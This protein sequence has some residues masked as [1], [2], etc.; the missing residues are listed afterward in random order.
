M[1]DELPDRLP[2]LPLA[3][4]QLRSEPELR[5]AVARWLTGQGVRLTGRM[6]SVA[7]EPDLITATHDTIYELKLVLNRPAIYSGLGQL[8][9]YRQAINPQAR[10]VLVGYA[11][12]DTLALQP[13]L[14]GLG[15]EVLPWQD[16]G[17]REGETHP[18]PVPV[19]PEEPAA[20]AL[21]V[22]PPPI[23]HLHILHWNVAALA[24]ARGIA[25][26]S[27]LATHMGI[28]RQGLYAIWRGEAAQVSLDILARLAHALDADPGAWFVGREARDDGGTGDAA[29]RASPLLWN[30]AAQAEG[31]GLKITALGFATGLHSR[32]LSTIWHGEAQAVGLESL[33]K[34]ALALDRP[35]RPFHIGDLFVWRAPPGA[36]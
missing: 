13:L 20:P 21:V 26:A 15:V 30:I 32:S 16:A 36:G 19:P 29:R 28:S 7:G 31:C 3:R 5:A 25:N 24:Q 10:V 9:L 35:E 11:T 8:L 22:A 6:V 1:P 4:R 14:D 2:S 23:A 12:P 27:A 33:A 17:A 34:L 18:T